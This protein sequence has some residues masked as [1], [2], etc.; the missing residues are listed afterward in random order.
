MSI[1]LDVK[2]GTE[3]WFHARHGL[4]TG[5]LA[6]AVMNTGRKSNEK[7]GKGFYDAAFMLAV[8]QKYGKTE[9]FSGYWLDRGIELEPDSIEAFEFTTFLEVETDGFYKTEC[10]RFGY[11]P[12]GITE[13]GLLECK[14][15]KLINHCLYVMNKVVPVAYIPQ[16]QLGLHVL[17]LDKGHFCSHHPSLKKPFIKE[18]GRDEKFIKDFLVRAEILLNEKEK[19]LQKI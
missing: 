7:F 18:F 14:N 13:I 5:S 9:G 19:Y 17:E 11:S 10:G 2:Q 15:P 3:E 8:Q 1:K 12:D 16:V 4:I 6:S